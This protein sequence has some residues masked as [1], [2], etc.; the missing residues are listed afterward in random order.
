MLNILY[1]MLIPYTGYYPSFKGKKEKPSSSV[2][3]RVRVI[4]PTCK[5]LIE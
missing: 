3:V 5:Y 1:C 2:D 4:G